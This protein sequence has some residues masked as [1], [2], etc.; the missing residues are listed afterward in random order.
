M[1]CSSPF[2]YYADVKVAYNSFTISLSGGYTL[3]AYT[4]PPLE[5]CLLLWQTPQCNGTKTW[6]VCVPYCT[7]WGWSG[8]TLKCTSWAEDCANVQTGC[9]SWSSGYAYWGDCWTT[10]NLTLWP[11]LNFM[12][13]ASINFTGQFGVGE[14]WTVS[15]PEGK[16]YQASTITVND[17]DVGFTING[18][19]NADG[20]PFSFNVPANVSFSESNGSF[21]ASWPLGT[22]NETYNYA[23]FTYTAAIT[24]YILGCLTPVPPVGWINLQFDITLTVTYDTTSQSSVLGSAGFNVVVPI[25]SVDE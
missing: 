15:A 17:F 1:S 7:G 3:P 2:A 5:V 19:N 12:F 10:P 18:M 25:V 11:E 20:L 13:N 9:D 8:W 22:I 14:V 24:V 4:T 6:G 16:P 23:G 21:S